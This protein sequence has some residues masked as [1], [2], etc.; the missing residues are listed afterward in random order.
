MRTE[1]ISP[2][3]LAINPIITSL[4]DVGTLGTGAG[5][6]VFPADTGGTH[7][8]PIFFKKY[9]T[10]LATLFIYAI[11]HTLSVTVI[12]GIITNGGKFMTQGNLTL[13]SMFWR[14]EIVLTLSL[15]C[16]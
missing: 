8:L 12:T 16:Y 3:L 4:M 2:M 10:V 6:G 1:I 13:G 7:S 5:A 11:S 15:E 9:L 14:C